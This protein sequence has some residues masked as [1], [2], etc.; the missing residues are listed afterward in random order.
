MFIPTVRFAVTV[1]LGLGLVGGLVSL[2]QASTVINPSCGDTIG[3][4]GSFVLGG[5]VGPCGTD[6]ALTVD[7]AKLDLGGFTVTCDGT[8]DGILLDGKGAQLL[9]GTVSHCLDGVGLVGSGKHTVKNVT[10]EYNAGVGFNVISD[11]NRLLSNTACNNDD[12]GFDIEGNKNTLEDN[13]SENNGGDGFDIEGNKTI[14]KDNV[15]ENNA[16]KGFLVQGF[17]N[18]LVDNTANNNGG[19][20][21]DIE[22]DKNHLIGNTA[23]TNGNDGI[24]VQA[25]ETVR[26]TGNVIRKNTA[27]GNAANDL[28]DGNAACDSNVWK[29]N[30]FGTSSQA[31]I[32]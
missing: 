14:V 1:I 3:P 17:F 10:S 25:G 15:A 13:L 28:E 23:N 8:F 5:D 9:N 22:G 26:S 21:F 24:D 16:D 6:P 27:T 19:D 30:T 20:G 7:S 2:P 12:G 18:K 29:N 31:C 32:E 11:K 4:G